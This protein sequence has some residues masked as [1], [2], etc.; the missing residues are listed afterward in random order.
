MR[1]EIKKSE[2]TILR[3]LISL[4]ENLL[5]AHCVNPY[6]DTASEIDN[7]ILV[8]S[9]SKRPGSDEENFEKD[10]MLNTASPD[11]HDKLVLTFYGRSNPKRA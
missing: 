3:A 5:I 9:S 7:M 4:S 11:L 6:A 8:Q 1:D 2:I 10:D